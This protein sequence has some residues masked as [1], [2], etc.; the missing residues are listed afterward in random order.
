M[1]CVSGRISPAAEAVG[2]L[3]TPKRT[4]V[5]LGVSDVKMEEGS[6]RCDANV[7]I[8]LRG[9]TAFGTKTEIEYGLVPSVYRAIRASSNARSPCSKRGPHRAGN[10]VGTKPG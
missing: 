9:T 10:A 1:E 6:L 7:S 4:F 5:E 8:R 3:E 2:Y